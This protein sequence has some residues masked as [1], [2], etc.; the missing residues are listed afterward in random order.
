MPI[1]IAR[2]GEQFTTLPGSESPP[3][4]TLFCNPN[5]F[6]SLSRSLYYFGAAALTCDVTFQ[7]DT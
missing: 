6:A 7:H 4:L 2:R 3:T 5:D 1:K